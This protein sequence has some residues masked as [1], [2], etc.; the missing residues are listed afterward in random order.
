MKQM[1]ISA[2]EIKDIRTALINEF[3]RR[4]NPIAGGLSGVS[5]A[6]FSTT[7]AA[8]GLIRA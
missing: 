2:T 6:A 4:A 5:I 3:A 8:G 1:A 7:P